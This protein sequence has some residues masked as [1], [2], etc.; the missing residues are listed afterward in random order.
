MVQG[1]LQRYQYHCHREGFGEPW[2]QGDQQDDQRI[3]SG[4]SHED[5]LKDLDV[6]TKNGDLGIRD[7]PLA[8]LLLYLAE[9]G[10]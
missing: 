5:L 9:K 10:G 2:N 3:E 6:F 4:V 1:V 7:G 8:S